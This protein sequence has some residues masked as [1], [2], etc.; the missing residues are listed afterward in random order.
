MARPESAQIKTRLRA[1]GVHRRSLPRRRR[2]ILT[3]VA[4]LLIISRVAHWT[5]CFVIRRWGMGASVWRARC[6]ETEASRIFR[7][8][9]GFQLPAGLDAL[10]TVRSGVLSGT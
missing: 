3:P 1:T 8:A 2:W 5:G 9:D 4:E 10:R 7:G 6:P